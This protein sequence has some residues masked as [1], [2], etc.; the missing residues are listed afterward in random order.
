MFDK[1][2]MN[3][4]T[5]LKMATTSA[6]ASMLPL[7]LVDVCWGK[8][9]GEKFTFASISD[10][11]LTHIKGT[12]FVNNFDKGLQQA[13]A[14]L[15]LMWPQPDFLVFG[16]DLAQL[17]KKEEIDHGLEMLSKVEVPIKFVI[18]EHDYYLD[19]GRYWEEKVSKL[20]YSFDHKGV[21]FVTLNSI[22]TYEDWIKRWPAPMDR[23]LQM[24]RLDNPQPGR[25]AY[26]LARARR[27]SLG[28][29]HQ[30]GQS[31]AGHRGRGP[32]HPPVG[33]DGPQPGR[34]AYRPA[35]TRGSRV[36]HR[37]QRRQP[38]AGHRQPGSDSRPVGH[39]GAARRRPDRRRPCR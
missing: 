19:M 21:H 7:K 12:R 20:H 31:L 13:V 25:C 36:D 10:A 18:G 30:P 15:G 29:R 38:L 22:L 24:A 16:G 23:M 27:A 2:P 11:H 1:K 32:H 5:F 17:G 4:R 35:R 8:K 33:P 37:H 26:H 28:S 6:A 39:L 9:E 14:E 34:H 3:R